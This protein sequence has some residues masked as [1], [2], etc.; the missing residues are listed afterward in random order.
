MQ[1]NLGRF[2]TLMTEQFLDHANV[3]SAFEQVRGE[4][5]TEDVTGDSLGDT[6]LLGNDGNRSLI[7]FV[8]LMVTPDNAT[9]RIA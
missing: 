4:T 7:G 5:M 2:N 3:H 9:A 6:G 8:Q 1:V